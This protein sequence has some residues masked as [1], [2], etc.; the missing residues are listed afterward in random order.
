M[1]M[2]SSHTKP[3]ACPLG[4]SPATTRRGPYI[5]IARVAQHPVEPVDVVNTVNVVRDWL[6][7][8]VSALGVAASLI[9]GAF[10]LFL[11]LRAIRLSREAETRSRTSLPPCE[12]ASS[13]WRSCA[14]WEAPP[15]MARPSL[16]TSPAGWPSS[17][18]LPEWRRYMDLRLIQSD[19]GILCP[20]FLGIPSPEPGSAY[21]LRAR[22]VLRADVLKAIERRVTDGVE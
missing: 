7:F 4:C 16:K 17:G 13:S 14:T 18:D 10:A 12:S 22:V 1:L 6:E 21:Q 9:I 20:R 8:T 2:M 3:N 15:P 19:L 11:A 5:L